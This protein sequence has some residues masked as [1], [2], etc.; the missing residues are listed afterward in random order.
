[1]PFKSIVLPKHLYA[2]TRHTPI[3]CSLQFLFQRWGAVD[4]IIVR[5]GRNL[6]ENG[7]HFLSRLECYSINVRG[8][9]VCRCN[10]I[11]D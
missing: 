11:E 2:F 7:E 6:L 1:M 3:P 5:R 4:G 9:Q 10:G 8:S